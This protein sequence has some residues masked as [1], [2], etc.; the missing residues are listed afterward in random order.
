M[1][2]SKPT[3][4]A[5]DDDGVWYCDAHGTYDCRRCAKM[6]APTARELLIEHS[7]PDECP[8]Y[9]DRCW[10]RCMPEVA[11]ALAARVEAVI[12]LALESRRKAMAGDGY[13][14]IHAHEVLMILDGEKP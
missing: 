1:S 2:A 11:D 7:T 3:W 13:G 4:P 12:A 6:T 5:H 9:Y 14:L 8:N 10:C